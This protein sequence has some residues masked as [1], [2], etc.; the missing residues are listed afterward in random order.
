MGFSCIG[1]FFYLWYNVFNLEGYMGRANQVKIDKN[2]GVVGGFI[3]EN[4]AARSRL[5][6]NDLIKRRQEE[7]KIEKKT[8][9]MIF[10]GVAAVG[11]VV[12]AIL[13]L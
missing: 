5:N 6:L 7:K 13:S 1:R 2:R 9:L 11:A 8:N 10:S 4:F 3:E 12:L